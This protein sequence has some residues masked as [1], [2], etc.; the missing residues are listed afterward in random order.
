[1][2]GAAAVCGGDRHAKLGNTPDVPAGPAG[3][4]C[5]CRHKAHHAEAQWQQVPGPGTE[6]LE[7]VAATD[8]WRQLVH[9]L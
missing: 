3:L 9:R 5:M 8:A 4:C 6:S 2:R 1:M 7:P